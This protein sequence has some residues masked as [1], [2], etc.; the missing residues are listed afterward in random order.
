VLR[1]AIERKAPLAAGVADRIEVVAVDQEYRCA[2]GVELLLDSRVFAAALWCT[3]FSTLC[4]PER[5][6]GG[7]VTVSGEL[8]YS[9][10]ISRAMAA[11]SRKASRRGR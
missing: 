1:S 8:G 6:A 2:E 7:G 3:A 4:R 5:I 11:S 10:C 9:L